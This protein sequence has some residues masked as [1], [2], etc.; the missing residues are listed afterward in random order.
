MGRRRRARYTWLPVLGSEQGI[1]TATYQDMFVAA[2]SG[3]TSTGCIPILQD[4]LQEDPAETGQSM[5]DIVG[6]EY[7]VRRIVGKVFAYPE[8]ANTGSSGN[9]APA[10]LPALWLKCGIFVARAEDASSGSVPI[11]YS[12]N[13]N[14]YNP[15]AKENCREPWLW[16]RSW[17]LSCTRGFSQPNGDYGGEAEV[18][19]AQNSV[20]FPTS[21]A[22]YGSAVDGGH[23]D[24]K[25]ARRVGQD[26]RL[27]FIANVEVFSFDL[28]RG[29]LPVNTTMGMN[30]RLD[31]RAL[32]A[33]RKARQKSSF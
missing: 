22:F 12:G 23:V 27:Y 11:G 19:L 29:E 25:V 26:D 5:S 10:V 9:A 17:I 24:V 13:P 30:I 3:S 33:L 31:F 28:G 8:G 14:E 20:A 21:T 2:V 4:P 15:A 7:V 18:A 32:G 16:Q 1:D 6:S